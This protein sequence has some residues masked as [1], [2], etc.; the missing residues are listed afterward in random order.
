[1]IFPCVC[2][3]SQR[4]GFEIDSISN[5]HPYFRLWNQPLWAL[6]CQTAGLDNYVDSPHVQVSPHTA[7]T[8]DR[9]PPPTTVS[10]KEEVEVLLS[11]N[12]AVVVV[13]QKSS[14]CTITKLNT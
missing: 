11:T 10:G 4:N 6:A 13:R 5:V 2:A 1:M 12:A 3:D 7:D 8:E 14:T 9:V